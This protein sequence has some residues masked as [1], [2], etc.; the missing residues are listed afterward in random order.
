MYVYVYVYVYMY[1]YVYICIHIL[2]EVYFYLCRDGPRSLCTVHILS[3][4]KA[5]YMSQILWA[6]QKYSSKSLV[7]LTYCIH[8]Y[9][10]L[11]SLCNP[12]FRACSLVQV[13]AISPASWVLHLV[14]CRDFLLGLRGPEKGAYSIPP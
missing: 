8:M 3:P 11:S 4:T 14:A 13:F 7:V 5:V 2:V 12:K 9:I 10:Y 1:V 6:D